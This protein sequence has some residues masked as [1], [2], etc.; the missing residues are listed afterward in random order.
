MQKYY[1]ILLLVLPTLLCAQN[2]KQ[3]L[4]KETVTVSKTTKKPLQK[5][6]HWIQTLEGNTIVKAKLEKQYNTEGKL[7]RILKNEVVTTSFVYEKDK[8]IK[9]VKAIPNDLVTYYY[10]NEKG[11][12]TEEKTY[13]KKGEN[14]NDW[15]L[16]EWSIN[17]YTE[18]GLIGKRYKKSTRPELYKIVYLYSYKTG[19]ITDII[20]YHQH[21][22]DN[23]KKKIE[24]CF[25]DKHTES[26]AYN[27]EGK[28]LHEKQ[29]GLQQ[30]KEYT[31]TS[32]G[33]LWYI[34]VRNTTQIIK[35]IYKNGKLVTSKFYA[36][37]NPMDYTKLKE[38]GLQKVI[39]YQYFY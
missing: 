31:Y 15:V 20:V 28:L 12:V 9:T 39:N 25:N 3:I 2:Q 21:H 35:H 38:E 7:L 5:V 23:G 36:L 18:E 8:Y 1:Y 33:K 27:T 4:Q 6:I 14:L 13:L 26:Y 34:T 24:V 16:Q 22:L 19:L 32:E 11:Q 17:T 37:A 10:T 30:T 29:A